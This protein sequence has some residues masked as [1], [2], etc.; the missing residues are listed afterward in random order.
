MKNILKISLFSLLFLSLA[1]TKEDNELTG[2]ENTG[3]L[4]TNVTPA[5]LYAQGSNPSDLMSASFTTFHGPDQIDK[6]DVYVQ[7]F[8]KIN[9]GTSNE[10][11]VSSNN[12]LLTTLTFPFDNQTESLSFS[13]DFTDITDGLTFNGAPMST[14]DDSVLEI[15]DYWRLTYVSTLSDGTTEHLNRS[16]TRIN[17]ACGSFLAG[18]Y[19]INNNPALT[20]TTT[21]LGGGAYTCSRLPYLTVSGGQPIPFEFSDLCDT[22]T[23][24]TTVLGGG[25]LVLGEGV[26]NPDG[27]YTITYALYNGPTEDT[28]IYFDFTNQPATYYPL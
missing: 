7:Y 9:V 23:I 11:V 10:Q 16:T 25:Y 26:V 15:G 14:S 2:N 28:G 6:V 20:A 21:A 17:V 12:K 3:G 24:N 22:I 8:G 18:N 19:L 13:F 1:C 4:L 5:I 27:S